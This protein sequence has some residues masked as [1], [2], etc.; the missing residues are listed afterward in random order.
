M[1]RKTIPRCPRCDKEPIE[2][3]ETVT[4]DWVFVVQDGVI[5]EAF[6]GEAAT[7][8][9]PVRAVCACR[10]QWTLRGVSQIIELPLKESDRLG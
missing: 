10:H 3:L 9:P 8:G 1:K 4:V 5:E 6:A 2:Y 7:H